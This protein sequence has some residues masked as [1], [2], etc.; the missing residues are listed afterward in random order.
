MEPCET[1]QV[2]D[3]GSDPVLMNSR[4]IIDQ[5]KVTLKVD[6]KRVRLEYNNKKRIII[7]SRFL[8]HKFLLPYQLVSLFI[9]IHSNVP[10][11]VKEKK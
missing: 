1:A 9:M 4:S 10:F 7:F 5:P 3:P 8:N 2:M 6:V 11:V